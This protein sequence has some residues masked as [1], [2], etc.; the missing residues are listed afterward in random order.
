[1]ISILIPI[2]N[3]DITALV[4]KLVDQCVKAKIRFEVICF[5]DGSSPKFKAKNQA[6][7]NLMSVNYVEM[8]Q[9]YGRSKIRN[10]LAKVAQYDYLLF[11]D[12]DSKI[13][14][15]SFI[16]NYVKEIKKEVDVCYGGRFYKKSK[17]RAKGKILHWKYGTTREALPLKK[18]NKKPYLTFL[19]NNFLVHRE[20]FLQ[21][22]FDESIQGY[23]YEDLVLARVLEYNEI[24]VVHIHN[25]TEHIDLVKTNDFLAKAETATENLKNLIK[26]GK[27]KET[28][29]SKTADFLSK[30]GLEKLFIKW[31]SR[32]KETIMSNLAS[33][34]PSMRYLDAYKLAL[35]LSD[36]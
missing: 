5:D 34:E 21:I 14:Y 12:C 10:K 27:I 1:M 16:K 30:F 28:K 3:F 31:Y 17:P 22:L 33:K 6:V 23:G 25:P 9:N 11:L 19:S 13:K 36:D 32:K 2:Y 7:L 29:L 18:R 24:E 20:L 35:F 4:Q 15:A 26:Q 8:S